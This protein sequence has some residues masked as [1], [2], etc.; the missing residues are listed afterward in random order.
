MNREADVAIWI[1]GEG[2]TRRNSIKLGRDAINEINKMGT[3]INKMGR[4]TLDKNQ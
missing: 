2:Y 1:M 4:G 3:K